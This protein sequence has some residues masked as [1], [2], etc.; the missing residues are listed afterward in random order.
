[1]KEGQ[2]IDHFFRD[3]LKDHELAAP[4]HLWEQVAGALADDGDVQRND[5]KR[6]R[7]L[8]P[9]LLLAMVGC[10]LA[11]FFAS[12]P[13]ARSLQSFPVRTM[14]HQVIPADL[15]VGTSIPQA[16]SMAPVAALKQQTTGTAVGPEQITALNSETPSRHTTSPPSEISRSGTA[17]SRPEQ[18]PSSTVARPKQVD[19][20]E[21]LEMARP[22]LAFEQ[23]SAELAFQL[24][25]VR[26]W[27]TRVDFMASMDYVLRD[28][29][30]VD[31]GFIAYANRR[32]A[33]E[34]FRHG[35]SFS[36]RFSS[37]S[38][39]GLAVRSG[40]HY[41]AIN[42]QLN[43]KIGEE[44]RLVAQIKYAENGS[45]IGTDTT[46]ALVGTYRIVNNRYTEL[47][48]PLL[49]GYEY[50]GGK[51]SFSLNGGIL[52]NMLSAQ[53]G[54]FLSPNT[55]EAVSFSSA[56]PNAYRAFRNRLGLGFY[57]SMGAYFQINEQLQFVLE[58]YFKW[59]PGSYT[60]EGYGL[61]QRYS[62]AGLFVGL[63]K[64][65]Y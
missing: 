40:L 25:P 2:D 3:R 22:A 4:M 61:E 26:T 58:P 13:T 14:D 64:A 41:A 44:E 62:T 21:L 60:V 7:Y 57:G 10:F 46:L 8:L 36:M 65:I 18:L 20:L 5:R 29:E 32:D 23:P 28:L 12:R 30:A 59:R 49:L 34:V 37:V 27:R 45:I 11:F 50:T 56:D 17:A 63:R 9:I 53:R 42:E 48:I 15:P 54:E 39:R 19:L 52:V 43:L 24:P 55:D 47:D 31:A 16:A 6:K 51:V 33:T 38:D 35:T 1:M